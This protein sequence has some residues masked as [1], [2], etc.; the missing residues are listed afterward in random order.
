MKIIKGLQT[1]RKFLNQKKNET[2]FFPVTSYPSSP[3]PRIS[4][5]VSHKHKFIYYQIPKAA[6][7]TIKSFIIRVDDIER[8]PSVHTTN[9]PVLSSSESRSPLYKNYFHFTFVRNPYDRLLSCYMDKVSNPAS[10][11]LTDPVFINGE[12]RPFLDKYGKLGW[13]KMSFEDFVRFVTKISDKHCD[14]HF[15][16]QNRFLNLDSLDFI[17]RLENFDRDFSHVKEKLSLS[18]DI[19]PER[20]M[21]SKHD[22]Y[23]TYYNDELRQLV[24]KK[25]AKD[26]EI[27]N[28]DF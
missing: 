25:Y 16:S 11:D 24:A 9:I 10:S 18:D 27:F 2:G 15:A 4:G 28:Y 12:Y 1:V 22:H 21:T 26:I 3:A 5:F 19:K 20:L 14:P 6:C 8:G 17:G 23:R 13:K 7:T